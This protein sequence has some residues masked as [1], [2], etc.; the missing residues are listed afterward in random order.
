M[1][2]TQKPRG[3]PRTARL[4]GARSTLSLRITASLFDQLDHAAKKDGRALSNEAERRLE[5]SFRDSE[6]LDEAGRLAYG[7][8]NNGLR[9]LVGLVINLLA[10]RGAWLDDAETSKAVG[11]GL[12]H[13]LR[14]LHAPE[15][16]RIEEH[17][18]AAR[19]DSMLWDL[20]D[21]GSAHPG[22]LSTSQRWAEEQRRRFG[23]TLSGRL[24][25]MHGAVKKALRSRP[26]R[27]PEPNPEIQ[28]LWDRAINKLN[29]DKAEGGHR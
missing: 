2:E 13:L 12:A 29:D 24:I 18:P 10:P 1:A 22:P 25:A 23:R 19:V 4:P 27:D 6:I 21:D 11:D 17:G 15:D 20:G 28:A 9:H 3:R 26:P 5:A 7:E 8:D 16:G 14:R